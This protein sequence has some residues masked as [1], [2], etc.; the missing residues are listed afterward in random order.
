MPPYWYSYSAYLYEVYVYVSMYESMCRFIF[1]LS[2]SLCLSLNIPSDVRFT[3]HL[4]Y[5]TQPDVA[6][7]PRS[8]LR[9]G[10]FSPYT[11][12]Q[13][14]PRIPILVSSFHLPSYT[15]LSP[16]FG[17]DVFV[18]FSQL[19]FLFLIKVFYIGLCY[20]FCFFTC[21]KV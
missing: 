1:S 20:L 4:S 6:R 14:I 17:I 13:H 9:G 18:F 10:S 15:L 11:C 19:C 5:R 2:V 3:H 21:N 16:Q 7:Y 12:S 8:P